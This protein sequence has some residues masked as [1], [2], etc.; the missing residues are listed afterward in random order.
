M[1]QVGTYINIVDK[2]GAKTVLC[3]CVLKNLKIADVGDKIIVVVKEAYKVQTRKKLAQ[4]SKIY[5]ALV[6]KKKIIKFGNSGLKVNFADK[7]AIILKRNENEAFSIRV[8]GG[9]SI[10]LREKGFSK[11]LSMANFII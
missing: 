5:Q 8:N 2:S 7:G 11:I 6:V 1:I 4:K 3:I 9:V 10:L